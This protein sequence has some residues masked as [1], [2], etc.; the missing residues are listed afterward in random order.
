MRNVKGRDIVDI[1][2]EFSL[3]DVTVR[4][5]PDETLNYSDPV[6]Y[7]AERLMSDFANSQNTGHIFCKLDSYLVMILYRSKSCCSRK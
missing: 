1:H 2:F 6:G 5:H 4:P 3:Y 7:T